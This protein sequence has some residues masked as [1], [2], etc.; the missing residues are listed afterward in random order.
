MEYPNRQRYFHRSRCCF[1]IVSRELSNYSKTKKKNKKTFKSSP[2]IDGE[3][4]IRRYTNS[5]IENDR[6]LFF[7]FS[8]LSRVGWKKRDKRYI[9]IYRFGTRGNSKGLATMEGSVFRDI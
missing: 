9:Y 3:R 4:C 8:K 5:C 1:H 6:I 7:I 2:V